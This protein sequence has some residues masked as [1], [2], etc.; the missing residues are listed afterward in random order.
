MQ[1]YLQLFTSTQKVCCD[2]VNAS[3]VKGSAQHECRPAR[4]WRKGTKV[5]LWQE[6]KEMDLMSPTMVT[7]V[8]ERNYISCKCIQAI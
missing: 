3:R 1:C 8:V 6:V 2:E 4:E 7:M 5:S